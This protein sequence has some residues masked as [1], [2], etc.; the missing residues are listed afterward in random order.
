MC[1]LFRKKV[2]ETGSSC[3]TCKLL[4]LRFLNNKKTTRRQQE[5]SV[6]SYEKYFKL[7]LHT[8]FGDDRRQYYGQKTDFYLS[9]YIF[10]IFENSPCAKNI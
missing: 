6:I 5:F 9:E 2:G 10:K 4:Q 7:T 1:L 3:Y 8:E